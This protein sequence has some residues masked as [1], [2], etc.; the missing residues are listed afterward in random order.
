[1]KFSLTTNMVIQ[2]C[3]IVAQIGTALLAQTALIHGNTALIIGAVVAVVQAV[4][5][6]V[7]H[8]S[9]PDGTPIATK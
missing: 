3:G 5:A 9:N 4:S 8:I 2:V 1:V 6:Y 7:G